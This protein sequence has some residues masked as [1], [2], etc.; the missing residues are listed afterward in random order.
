MVSETKFARI[1]DLNPLTFPKL[2]KVSQITKW[3]TVVILFLEVGVII[4]LVKY[5]TYKKVTDI[6][7]FAAITEFLSDIVSTLLNLYALLVYR[8]KNVVYLEDLTGFD[9]CMRAQRA[10][11]FDFHLL[12]ISAVLV[13][14]LYSIARIF[15]LYTT[16]YVVNVAINMFTVYQLSATKYLVSK[17]VRLVAERIAESEDT[18]E[19]IGLVRRILQ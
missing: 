1:Y 7:S 15:P 9:L 4:S 11:A 5:I 10:F 2:R 14:H 12:F 6:Q 8:C 13:I 19:F 16:L 18:L 3:N 17:R